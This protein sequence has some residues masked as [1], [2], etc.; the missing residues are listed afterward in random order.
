LVAFIAVV[1]YLCYEPR[2]DA[3]PFLYTP[4]SFTLPRLEANS[5]LKDNLDIQL[6][7]HGIVAAEHFAFGADGGIYFGNH[8]GRIM[9]TYVDASSPEEA[10]LPPETVVYTGNPLLA[11]REKP[12]GHRDSEIVCG[13]PL[14]MAFDK[15]KKTLYVADALGLIAVDVTNKKKEI[16]V[17]SVEN[18][19]PLY[20]TN[21][22]VVGP[23]TGLVYF[24]DS[25]LRWRRKDFTFE[26]MEG[27]STGR[28]L[29]Y[30]PVTKKTV[31]LVE[32][33]AFANGILVDQDKEEWL[34]VNELTR[35][36]IIKIDLTLLPATPLQLTAS[37]EAVYYEAYDWGHTE[38]ALQN[39]I[40]TGG[41]VE[42]VL[43]N[44]PGSQ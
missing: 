31:V 14:G 9:R 5:R 30:N 23:K 25:S 13:R 3:I 6:K 26:C 11:E 1:I 41:L 15:A 34:L 38:A 39:Y 43:E 17:Q 36:R 21:S 28:V 10:L 33:I 2:I 8:D 24:T 20:F 35:A 29:V 12:C 4:S 42:I 18:A 37:E 40:R 7:G 19:Q 44:M 32:A 27:R 16:I 22:V